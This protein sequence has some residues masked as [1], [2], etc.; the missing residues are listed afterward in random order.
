[1]SSSLHLVPDPKAEDREPRV[2]SPIRVVVADAHEGMRRGLGMVLEA[3]PDIEVVAEAA[4]PT[5]TVAAIARHTPDV[6][7]LDLY[8][9]N[10]TEGR[11]LLQRG[12]VGVIVQGM[13]DVPTLA[14]R[15]LA[16]GALGF[17]R[18]Q[19]ADIELVPAVR[20]AARREPYVA[21]PIAAREEPGRQEAARSGDS[22][23][24]GSLPRFGSISTF[25]GDTGRRS[26]E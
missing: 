5:G 22:P 15:A 4:D 21:P 9:S 17:V 11:R 14:Q 26:V 7:V 16:L 25:P 10:S 18:K 1:M 12:D 6:V 2:P 19:F 23:S 20:A 13:E 3:Q 8:M 24:L